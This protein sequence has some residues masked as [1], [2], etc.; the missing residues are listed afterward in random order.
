MNSELSNLAER[1][2]ILPET[3]NAGLPRGD[4]R[5]QPAVPLVRVAVLIPCYNEA[6][7]IGRVV[8]DMRQA[9][10]QVDAATEIYV[11]DNNS[12]D[13]SRD[14]AR[15]AGAIV[16]TETLQ[17]KGNVVRRMFRDVEADFYIM[18]DGDDTYDAAIAPA[19]L[20]L[21]LEGP[22]DLVNCVR[23]DTEQAA[24]RLGHRFGNEMLTGMV[25]R[26]F[27]DQIKDMLSGYKVLSRRFVKSFPALSR[28]FDTE[29]E[30]TVHALELSLPV[31]HIGGA[32]RGRPEGSQSKLNTY[33]D[34]IRILWLIIV[35]FKHERPIQLFSLIAL[36]LA[37]ISLGFG[38]P[39]VLHYVHTGLVPRLPSA[40]LAT[41]L[42]LLA[43]LSF[44]TGLILDTVTRGR[45]E[46]RMLAYLQYASLAVP[47]ENPLQ[48]SV[49]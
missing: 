27:G 47:L 43:S 20:K 38:I 7:T 6:L 28:G 21:A 40:V 44:I 3:Q 42:M 32:Y 29:T 8:A 46:A 34:G 25:R 36:C 13:H 14:A 35:L 31:A 37:L 41:G 9:L 15:A 11:Y 16:R 18:V 45:R 30:L 33:K 39:V 49:P 1:R 4:L 22:Y 19:M 17:G 10:S 5:N 2:I 48:S 26:I 12:S 23:R 24:Y